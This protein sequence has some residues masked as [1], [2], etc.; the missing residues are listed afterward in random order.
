VRKTDYRVIAEQY[1]AHR[2]VNPR[3]AELLAK[4]VHRGSWVLEVGCGTANYLATVCAL[5]AADGIGVDPSPEM[6]AAVPGTD[7][8][9]RT[10][11]G[12]A[13]QLCVATG[14]FDLIY[15]VDVI[16]HV[17]DREAS[18][19]EAFRVLRKEGRVCT[20]TESDVMLRTREPQSRYFP[21]TIDVELARYPS[22][23]TLRTEMRRAGFQYL[24]E[25]VAEWA[26][27]VTE[28]VP[29]RAK[30]FSSLL[31]IDEKAFEI[32]LAGLE[33]DLARS[34]VP[35]VSRYLLLWG[36]KPGNA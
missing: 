23:E 18:Y 20:V 9:A 34:S 32:G 33:A 11:M 5:S 10:V 36:T 12:R 15:S 4:T 1:A 13:E 14:L 27:E 24:S 25:D 2:R 3:V 29:F 17:T 30:V 16:H 19:H 26:D 28:A 7:I 8:R 35:Y 6:L 31:Y 22:I 21:Q